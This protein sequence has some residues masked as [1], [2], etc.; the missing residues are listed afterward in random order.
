MSFMSIYW[1]I[2][3]LV[4]LFIELAT[5]NLV[6]IWFAIGAVAAFITSFF[7]DSILWQLLVFV[8]VSVVALFITLP[9][10]RKAKKNRK[11]VPTN[12]DRIIGKQAEVTKEIKPNHYGEVQVFGKVW[13][14]TSDDS[15]DV[16]DKVIVDSIDGVKLIVRKEEEK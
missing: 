10:V 12:L 9:M 1:I 7:T 15:F 2:L 5:V 3:F 6:S 16:G 4:L 13:T 11:P 8:V 14:A